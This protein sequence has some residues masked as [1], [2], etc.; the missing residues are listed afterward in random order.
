MIEWH[1]DRETLE[2]FLDDELPEELSRTLQRHLFTCSGCEERLIDI[3]PAPS[4]GARR[5]PARY[6]F[7]AARRLP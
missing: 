5:G 1:P 3:L 2:R 6:G 7:D 4:C